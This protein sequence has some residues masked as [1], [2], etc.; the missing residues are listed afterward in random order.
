MPLSPPA[1]RDPI[2]VRRVECRG[3]RRADGLWDV[4]GHMTDVK[5]YAFDNEHRGRIEPGTPLHDI[6]LRLTLD[7]RM[8]IRAVEAVTDAAPTA[9]ARSE[10]HTSELQS[11]M[12]ISYAVFCLKK[13][14]II[15]QTKREIT[16]RALNA[17]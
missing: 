15:E 13:Q 17:R 9:S 14:K 6:W 7:D 5:A 8:E 3:Y 11:L 10:E 1:E 4:E 12:R 2:H 16:R